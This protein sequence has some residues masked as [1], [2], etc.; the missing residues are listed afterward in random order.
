MTPRPIGW[1]PSEWWYVLPILRS[2]LHIII[3][4]DTD[5]RERD[6]DDG[7]WSSFALRVGSSEQVVRVLPSTAGQ[8]TWVVS[9]QGCPPGRNGTS[10]SSP[11]SQSRGGLF[12]STQSSS[13]QTIGNYKLELELNLDYN[14][15][16]VYGF[17]TVALGLTNSIGGPT[18]NSQVISALESDD[19][20]L[21][22]FGLS[23]QGTNISNFT[24]PQPTFLTAMRDKSLIP[25]LS[26][27]YTAGAPYREFVSL[28]SALLTHRLIT[29]IAA[30]RTISRALVARQSGCE[31]KLGVL[32]VF[33]L[34]CLSLSEHTGIASRNTRNEPR[35]CGFFFFSRLCTLKGGL[36]LHLTFS[37]IKRESR[38]LRQG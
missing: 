13:W 36:L 11:C 12:D 3:N 22:V 15:T 10:P 25:S 26:W 17:D 23:N 34:Y 18:I 5:T 37:L 2:F 33:S 38:P 29:K 1:P 4:R 9:P 27:A 19:Y 21:G 6:G 24:D 28:L 8:E 31:P 20:Y 32:V 30:T 14:D 16:A 35:V 7:S